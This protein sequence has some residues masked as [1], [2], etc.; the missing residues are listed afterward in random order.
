MSETKSS[1]A[2]ATPTHLD[3]NGRLNIDI[4]CANCGYNLRG[5][6]A[7]GTCGECGHDVSDSLG[8]DRLVFSCPRWLRSMM[9]GFNWVLVGFVLEVIAVVVALMTLPSSRRTWDEIDLLTWAIPVPAGLIG[10]IGCWKWTSPEPDSPSEI[11]NSLRRFAR[12]AAVIAVVLIVGAGPCYFFHQRLGDT[13][14]S[15]GGVILFPGAFAALLYARWI[16]RRLPDAKL[17]AHIMLMIWMYGTFVVITALLWSMAPRYLDS[18]GPSVLL[19]GL[20]LSTGSIIATILWIIFS[21]CLGVWAFM[22]LLRFRFLLHRI[23]S[24]VAQ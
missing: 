4:P 12:L 21:V 19:F 16:A 6:V 9:T 10:F 20:Y 5:F 14:A 17:A 15:M 22:L 1:I 18:L 3:S 23:V 7:D 11:E 24:V 13:L 8:A 2:P